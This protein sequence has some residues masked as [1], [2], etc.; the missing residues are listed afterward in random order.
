MNM[1]GMNA[2]AEPMAPRYANSGSLPPFANLPGFSQAGLTA[3][4]S[5]GMAMPAA[6]PAYMAAAP[7]QPAFPPASAAALAAA[8]AGPMGAAPRL[9]T[10]AS[11]PFSTLDAQ[12][13]PSAASSPPKGELVGLPAGLP[14][15]QPRSSLGS[16]SSGSASPD[17]DA[18]AGVGGWR[19]RAW[20]FDG[21]GSV[22]TAIRLRACPPCQPPD[23]PLP[24]PRFPPAANRLAMWQLQNE[25]LADSA[26]APADWPATAAQRLPAT[27]TVN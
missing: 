5:A 7:A 9:P 26:A 6:Q 10:G 12:A 8:L 14:L 25:L 24:C 27:A 21:S 23:V 16:G 15:M 19:G 1:A 11:S 18:A 17:L 20:C 3:Q 2:Y 13:H 4:A 22:N